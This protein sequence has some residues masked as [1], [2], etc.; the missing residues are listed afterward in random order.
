M[1]IY[2][3]DDEISKILDEID[4]MIDAEDGNLINT[5]TGEV[6]TFDAYKELQDKLD[7][8]GEKREEKISNIACWIKQLN[9]DAEAI[10]QEKINLEKRQK[11]CL[12]KVQSLKKYL[13][14]A[15]NGEKF[16][17][18]RVSISYRTSKQVDFAPD[19]DFSNLPKEF[20][21]IKIEPRKTELQKA[22]ENGQT[23]DGV[24]IK[25]NIN[26]QIK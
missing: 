22:I 11:S 2:E 23:F 8:L 12:N 13:N 1:T 10:K 18:A 24:I 17:D 7:K 3:L 9:A 21:R 19:F 20:Q 16:K 25:D 5:E 26:I 4:N 6:I 14:Y 15:L